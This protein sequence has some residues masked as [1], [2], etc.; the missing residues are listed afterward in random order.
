M[1]RWLIIDLQKD[2]VMIKISVVLFSVSMLLYLPHAKASQ[3]TNSSVSETSTYECEDMRCVKMYRQLKSYAK[4]GSHVAQVMVAVAYLTG[5]GL[6]I[7]PAK[8]IKTLRKASSGGSGRAAWML[9]HYYREGLVVEQDMALATQ[10]LDL[11][12]E[13]KFKDALFDKSTSKLDLTGTEDNTLA[14]EML[15]LA[16]EEQSFPAQYLIAKLHETGTV[17]P[18]DLLAAAKRYAYLAQ[19]GY[20]D[21]EQ[22][23]QQTI[24]LAKRNEQRDYEEIKN[25]VDDV[26]VINVTGTKFTLI[27][28]LGYIISSLESSGL[29]YNSAASRI[30]GKTCANSSSSCVFVK[31]PKK[32]LRGF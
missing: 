30:P 14:L 21:S 18:M 16:A 9:S 29:Y 11:A 3:A 13:R 2:V 5:N 22:R 1:L 6:P 10:Y 31:D 25:L 17:L 24:A 32:W 27:N 19:Q 4:N 7:N 28:K 26:E 12:V 15:F 20:R 23:L 8:G